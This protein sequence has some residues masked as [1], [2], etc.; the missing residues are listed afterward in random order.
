MLRFALVGKSGSGKSEVAKLLNQDFGCRIVKTGSICRQ[1]AQILFGNE[2]KRSTQILDDALTSIDPSI[3]L[4]AAIRGLDSNESIVIDALRFKS[5]L[6]IASALGCATIRVD[7]ADEER[8]RRLRVRGQTFDLKRDGHHR[9]ETELDDH[10]V[11]HIITN[12]GTICDLRLQVADI[13]TPR[14]K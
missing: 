3:F 8:V 12:A 10:P 14:L 5:D 1:I 6:Q 2:E 13:V 4:R 9:S 7:A 11:D